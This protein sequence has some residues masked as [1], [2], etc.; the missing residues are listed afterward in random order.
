VG[1]DDYPKRVGGDDYPKRVGR[2]RGGEI[3]AL[4]YQGT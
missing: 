3:L 1:R 2:G 4:R